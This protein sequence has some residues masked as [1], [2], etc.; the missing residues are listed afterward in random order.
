MNLGQPIPSRV[1]LLLF[2]E[3]TAEG[4]AE[5]GFLMATCP[6]HHSTISVKAWKEHKTLTHCGMA[7]FF[8]KT[9]SN[10]WCTDFGPDKTYD[11][12][13]YTTVG[14][15]LHQTVKI[16][17][18]DT[19][20]VIFVRPFVKRFALCYR[21]VV[22]MSVLSVYDIGVLW[23]YVWI[24]QNETRHEGRPWPW[25]HCARWGPTPTKRGTAPNFQPI[26]L[27]PNGH[28]SQLLLRACFNWGKQFTLAPALRQ[29]Q[30]Y[31]CI[32]N[33][34]SI[35]KSYNKIWTISHSF[36]QP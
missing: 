27:W 18:T 15:S 36:T 2:Q 11:R 17:L 35:T 25:P 14:F 32:S 34:I 12:Y 29:N 19:L 3:K 1:L 21:S 9:P 8:L 31:W 24:D 10:S 22:C 30:Y 4:L 26:L 20:S 16:V 28:P 33:R 13:A 23:P 6:S 5:S 7:L